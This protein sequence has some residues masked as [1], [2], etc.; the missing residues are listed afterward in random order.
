MVAVIESFDGVRNASG[1]FTHICEIID[2]IHAHAQGSMSY[3]ECVKYF[4]D[5]VSLLTDPNSQRVLNLL[6]RAPRITNEPPQ[7]AQAQ[8]YGQ[9]H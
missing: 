2:Q 3:A 5:T 4:Q 8:G 1:L 6:A 9:R 7:A